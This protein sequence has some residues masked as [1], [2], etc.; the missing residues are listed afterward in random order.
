M[1]IIRTGFV[2]GGLVLATL[3][4]PAMAQSASEIGYNQNALGVAA[5]MASDYRTAETQLGA[6]DGVTAGDPLRLINL[7]NVY[8]AT[9]RIFDAEKAY[10]AVLNTEAVDVMTAD[11]RETDTHAVARTALSRIHAVTAAR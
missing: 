8:A 4:A 11:G 5:L 9:G 7:G 3:A 2:I 6:M 1:V 10:V